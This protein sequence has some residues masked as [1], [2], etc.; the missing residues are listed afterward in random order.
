MF[1][2]LSYFVTWHLNGGKINRILK[3]F[4]FRTNI[5]CLRA[6]PRYITIVAL[7]AVRQMYRRAKGRFPFESIKGYAFRARCAPI[8]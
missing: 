6:A 1:Y 3:T 5:V 7:P 8:G 4:G 2:A